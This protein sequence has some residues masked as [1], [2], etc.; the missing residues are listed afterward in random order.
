M[1]SVFMMIE[2]KNGTGFRFLLF[3]EVVQILY[4]S[5]QRQHKPPFYTV[6]LVRRSVR[7]RSAAVKKEVL[8]IFEKRVGGTF[9]F[10]F[11]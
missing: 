3:R 4:N 5:K 2:N 10:S 1:Y 6:C 7:F 8:P 9:I 11:Q